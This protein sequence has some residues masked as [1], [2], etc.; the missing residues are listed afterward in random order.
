MAIYDNLSSEL[1]TVAIQD[2]IAIVT[3]N[4]PE[5]RNAL[6][7]NMVELLNQVFGGLPKTNARAVVL[8]ANGDH[9]SFYGNC[10]INCFV[11]HNIFFIN[12]IFRK[13]FFRYYIWN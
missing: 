10:C 11:L 5:K 13:F 3:L 8:T 4:R 1:L 9:F 7:E 2:H 6:D 12:S